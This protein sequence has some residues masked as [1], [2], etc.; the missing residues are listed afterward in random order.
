MK[1]LNIYYKMNKKINMIEKKINDNNNIIKD[2][3]HKNNE[4]NKKEKK[5]II[6]LLNLKLNKIIK[7]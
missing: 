2:A 7:I 6:S 1:I 3:N 5:K 4:M